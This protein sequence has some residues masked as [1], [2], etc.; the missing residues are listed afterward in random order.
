MV[1]MKPF[2][3]KLFP[4]FFTLF[5]GMPMLFSQ[6]ESDTTQIAFLY[7]VDASAE[8]VLVLIVCI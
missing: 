7:I 2:N 6:I 1:A 4:T 8:I 5:D 3:Y